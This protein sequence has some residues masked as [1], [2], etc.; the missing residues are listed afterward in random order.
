MGKEEEEA[1]RQNVASEKL[2]EMWRIERK[3]EGLQRRENV[4]SQGRESKVVVGRSA[5]VTERVR[6]TLRSRHERLQ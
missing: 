6:E 2:I 5:Y 3:K 1:E 4:A